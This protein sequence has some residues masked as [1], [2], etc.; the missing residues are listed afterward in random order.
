MNTI[1]VMKQALEALETY[2]KTGYWNTELLDS[3]ITALKQT[4]EQ[5][6]K[7]E[8]VAWM[9]YD[10]SALHFSNWNDADTP[11]FDLK[12]IKS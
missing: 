10:G 7:A 9:A 4:I 11:L 6:E 12:G 3:A 1:D 5:M 2:D 8:P